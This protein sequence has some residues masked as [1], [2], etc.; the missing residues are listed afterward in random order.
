MD[1]DVAEGSSGVEDIDNSKAL[2]F[3]EAHLSMLNNFLIEEEPDGVKMK[4]NPML[5]KAGQEYGTE[6]VGFAKDV[7]KETVVGLLEESPL[8]L[9][10]NLFQVGNKVTPIFKAGPS[11][12]ETMRAM[13]EKKEMGIRVHSDLEVMFTGM[14]FIIRWTNRY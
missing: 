1:E 10:T 8:G 9:A 14:A 7:A 12:A 5:L 3:E 6:L 2:A 11:P 4:M 13:K